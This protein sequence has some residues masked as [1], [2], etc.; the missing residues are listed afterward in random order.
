MNTFMM[1]KLFILVPAYNEEDCIS[2]VINLIPP[3]PEC[4]L[5]IVVID[6]GSIDNTRVLAKK[7]G[8]IVL[9]NSVN[10]GLGL[11]FRKGVK[12]CIDNDAD[13]LLVLDA[14]GQYSPQQIPVLIEP[15]I[16][17]KSDITIGNR[18]LK[19][20]NYYENRIKY[21][22]NYLVSFF[23]SRILLRRRT[24]Y[25]I[26]SSFRAFTRD[27]GK[28]LLINLKG[29]YNYAQ[30]V[31]MLVSLSGFRYQRRLGNRLLQPFRCQRRIM[32]KTFRL[33]VGL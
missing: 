3:I 24:F 11:T 1:K 15:L 32:R 23:I 14:D 17:N 29:K 26:Q 13:I 27:L 18:F 5:S 21:L 25:D 12:F 19:E 9:S 30:E 28:F 16:H 10:M 2:T 4:D 7:E 31:F 33:R 20:S 6:D 22:I 8:A